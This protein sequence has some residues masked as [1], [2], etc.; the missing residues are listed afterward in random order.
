MSRADSVVLWK[1]LIHRWGVIILKGKLLDAHCFSFIP[2]LWKEWNPCLQAQ[3]HLQFI[4]TVDGLGYSVTIFQVRGHLKG[5]NVH[6]GRLAQ[7]HELPQRHSEGP[8]RGRK[9]QDGYLEQLS[10]CQNSRFT[11]SYGK[12]KYYLPRPVSLSYWDKK[13]KKRHFSGCIL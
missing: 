12:A 4:R 2:K 13:K 1:S 7:S 11:N 3:K 6:I 10:E 5:V 9:A 8:L